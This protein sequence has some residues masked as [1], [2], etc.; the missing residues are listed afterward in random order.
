MKTLHKHLVL[1]VLMLTSTPFSY[2]Q[3]PFNYLYAESQCIPSSH[4]LVRM[5]SNSHVVSYYEIPGAK[6]LS[7]IL[8]NRCVRFP[9]R[10]PPKQRL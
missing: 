10:K 8:D 5:H 3:L 6:V 2:A 4:P 1:L 9:F 7:T